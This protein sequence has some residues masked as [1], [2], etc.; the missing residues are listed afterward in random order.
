MAQRFQVKK[1]NKE[2]HKKVN[3]AAKSVKQGV[4]VLG[5]IGAVAGVA[6]KFGKPVIK[7]VKNIIIR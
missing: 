4:G 5:V 3:N 2:D 6:V 7:V 1:L